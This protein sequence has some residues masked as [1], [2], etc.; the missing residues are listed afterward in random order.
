MRNFHLF[1]AFS[2]SLFITAQEVVVPAV[3]PEDNVTETYHGITIQDPYRYVENLEDPQVLSWMRDHSNYARATLEAIPGRKS[4]LDKFYE[5]DKRVSSR[6]GNTKITENGRYFYIKFRPEDDNGKLYYR[7]GYKGEEKMLFDPESYRPES[8]SNFVISNFFPDSH[9]DQVVLA[10]SPDGSENAELL[11]LKRN[12]TRL[13]ELIDRAS[14]WGI[15]WQPG[16]DSFTYTRYNSSDISDVNR[17]INMRSY[18]HT[19]GSSVENDLEY[20]STYTHPSLQIKPEEIPLIWYDNVN[21]YIYAL[22]VTVEDNLLLYIGKQAG[23]EAPKNLQKVFDREDKVTNFTS[24]KNFIYMKVYDGAP[25]YK[26]LRSPINT[27]NIKNA[28]EVIPE[29]ADEIIQDM[30]LTSDGLYYTTLKNGVEANAYFRGNN[31]EE[32]R[33]LMLPFAAG[34]ISLD[35]VD[36]GHPEVW[37]TLEGWTRPEKRYRYD[38]KTDQF[39]LEPLSSQAEYPELA[40]VEVTETTVPSHDGVM[41]PVSIIHKKGLIKNGKNPALIYGYGSYGATFSP[42]FSPVILNYVIHDGILVIAHV[43]GGGELGDKWYKAGQ[44][45]NKPNTWKDGIATAEYLVKEGYSSK[46]RLGIWGGS[47]GGIFVGRAMTERPDLFAYAIPEVGAMNTVRM[48][49]SPNGPVNAPEFGTVKDPEEFKSLLE[50]D[51]YLHLQDGV[52]YPATLVTAGFNDPRVIAWEPAK[53]AA[54]LQKSQKG[55]KPVLFLTDFEAGHGIGDSKS[56][57]FENFADTF[58]FAL[59]QGKHPDFQPVEKVKM[60]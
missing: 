50:M 32:A 29:S 56:K 2:F 21:K 57:V 20:F 46:D 25:H 16:N 13:P 58:A 10:V 44:K 36:A 40:E 48:E 33:K 5:L 30:R 27:P 28:V 24:D 12:G 54:R 34:S 1:L 15:S 22:P 3:L 47:A 49:A 4:V 38:G 45:K 8:E 9:G 51:S 7:E 17:Q 19:V 60:K 35:N 52:E 53:F 26:I 31:A 55:N 39:V 6:V 23:K 42:G 11:I 41:V 37:M 18:L 43:R 59:W 14:T